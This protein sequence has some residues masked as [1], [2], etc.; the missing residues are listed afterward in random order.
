MID[1]TTRYVISLFC[2]VGLVLHF[3][4]I[5]IFS[6]NHRTTSHTYWNTWQGALS[7]FPPHKLSCTH[8]QLWWLNQT[9]GSEEGMHCWAFGRSWDGC[10]HRCFSPCC[11]C[12]AWCPLGGRR[13]SRTTGLQQLLERKAWFPW[14]LAW[15][16]DTS[17][18]KSWLWQHHTC[19]ARAQARRTPISLQVVVTSLGHSSCQ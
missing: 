10:C 6:I 1:D 17:V 12:V 7:P 4:Q 3:V 8:P 19:P 2:R 15:P 13:R 14:P 18:S 11:L 5:V 9:L 16:H